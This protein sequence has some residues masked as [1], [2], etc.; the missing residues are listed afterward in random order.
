MGY[1]PFS[2]RRSRATLHR[3]VEV[4]EHER[5]SVLSWSVDLGA[6]LGEAP[7][8]EKLYAGGIGSIR[9]FGFRGVGPR[10]GLIDRDPI[11]GD[12]SLTTSVEYTI[13]LYG[14]MLQGVAFLDMGTVE[15]DITISSW[16]ASV[17]VGVRLTLGKALPFLGPLPMEFDFA[18]PVVSDEEDD[19]RIFSFYIGGNF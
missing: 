8:Y 3:P 14:D 1:R 12:F 7:L 15:E 16:R 10:G 19:E 5:R 4:N 2:K 6:I 11:G 13:P 17:G 9:G 18:I